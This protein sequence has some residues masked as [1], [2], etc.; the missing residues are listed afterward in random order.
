[1]NRNDFLLSVGFAG[2]G[3]TARRGDRSPGS[4]AAMQEPTTGIVNV[5]Q[6]GAKGDGTT[7][8]AGAIQAAL[9]GLASHGGGE[10]HFPAGSYRISTTIMLRDNVSLIGSMGTPTTSRSSPVSLLYAGTGA[11]FQCHKSS[12][13]P[14]GYLGIRIRGF[15][16]LDIGGKG[17]RGFDLDGYT[18]CTLEDCGIEGFDFGIFTKDDWYARYTNLMIAGARDTGAVFS[19]NSNSARFTNLRL[20]AMA[21]GAKGAM[22]LE[23]A[24]GVVLDNVCVETNTDGLTF[25][26]CLGV[27]VH[28]VYY[29]NAS[30]AQPEFGVLISNCSGVALDGVFMNGNHH[31][32]RGIYLFGDNHAVTIAGAYAIN[33]QEKDVVGPVNEI[34]MMHGS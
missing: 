26:H 9:D 10:V 4:I 20:S 15:Y 8:D 32:K 34:G 2:A 19:S 3:L 12:D 31:T 28:G 24:K 6:A 21:A 22:R 13:H 7:E 5:K 16:L 33:F 14:G 1:M 27:A 23:Y 18:W 17:T 29:E 30:N 25:N 11:A